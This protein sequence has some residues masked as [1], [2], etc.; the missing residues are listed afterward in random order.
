MSKID[1]LIA[2]RYPAP[3]LNATLEG[4]KNQTFTNFSVVLVIHGADLGLATLAK[5]YFP[6]VRIIPSPENLALPDVRNLGLNH[7]KAPFVALIDADDIPLPRRLEK[8]V[9]YLDAHPEIA[10]VTFQMT[11]IDTAGKPNGH[12][13]GAKTA[14]GIKIRLLFR[15]IIGQSSV[16]YRRDLAVEAGGYRHGTVGVEDYDLWL[17][18][19]LMNEVGVIGTSEVQYRVHEEQ[20]SKMTN[21]SLDACA[22]ILESRLALARKQHVPRFFVR[23][24]HSLWLR[25]NGVSK[26]HVMKSE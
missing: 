20:T 6:E 17:R 23:M 22:L 10:M 15:N 4:L 11:E 12:Y 26:K 9:A 16:M 24:T 2:V 19:A 1:V 7:C 13:R 3:W 25:K 18:I 8:Q 21:F 5:E 14:F